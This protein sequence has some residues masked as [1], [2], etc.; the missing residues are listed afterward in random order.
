MSNLTRGLKVFFTE[1]PINFD[2]DLVSFAESETDSVK[3]IYDRCIE[4]SIMSEREKPQKRNESNKKNNKHNNDSDSL[5]EDESIISGPDSDTEE[6]KYQNS[7]NK[8]QKGS[9]IS[10]SYTKDIS[11]EFIGMSNLDIKKH[12]KMAKKLSDKT[13]KKTS[14]IT[15]KKKDNSSD[16]SEDLEHMSSLEISDQSDEEDTELK[17]AK[18]R[19]IKHMDKIVE[20]IKAMEWG[21]MITVES[22]PSY[23]PVDRS[24]T[25]YCAITKVVRF[26]TYMFNGYGSK[27]ILR[28]FMN[29]T[30]TDPLYGYQKI[31]QML[32]NKS[33]RRFLPIKNWEDFW[34]A[35]SDEPINC[36]HVFELIRSDQPCKPYLDIEWNTDVN[37]DARKEDYS[38]FIEK[39]QDDLITI[40]K[41]RYKLTIDNDDIMI[42]TSHAASKVSFHVVIDKII[43]NKTVSYRTNRKGYPE[44]AWDLW[45]ALVEHDESYEDVLDGAVYTTDREFRVI[46]SNKTSEFRPILPYGSKKIKENSVVKMKMKDCLRYIITHSS[47]GEYHH[48][49]T[50]EVP[51]KYLVINKRYCDG[52]D[53]CVPR[54]YSDKKINHLMELIRPVHRTAE[55]T[56]RSACGKGWRFS[57]SDK[58]E[59]CYT[60]NYHESNGFYVFE[61]LEKGTT[62]MKCMS[63]NCKGIKVL[64]RPKK[65]VS[66]KKLF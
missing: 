24:T 37:Q 36:R 5:D 30:K 1:N 65:I 25:K 59:K 3:N 58:D 22:D 12:K 2:K 48:I 20:Q 6:C 34:K 47:S 29:K 11:D 17:L 62:Y 64:D 45:V 42:S 4:S 39:L 21:Q 43:N 53:P 49:R 19:Y 57:Y 16:D 63:E 13:S 27:N 33:Y 9:H 51:K 66:T 35:Y 26:G 23:R 10:P 50:P 60:G 44:S 28:Y 41:N 7:R 32:N 31:I 54:T 38:A 52:D 46:Y 55:Y 15:S 61:N 40:F 14:K 8:S 18:E 56:G